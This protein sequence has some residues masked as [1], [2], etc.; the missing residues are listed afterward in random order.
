M[1]G[2]KALEATIKNTGKETLPVHLALDGPDADRTHRK[3]CTV[4]SATIPSATE[5]TLV[6]PIVPVPPR[7]SEWL[8]DGKEKTFPWSDSSEKSGYNLAKANALSIYVYH[9]RQ[10]YVYEVARL[11]AIP[12][13]DPASVNEGSVGWEPRIQQPS[14]NVQ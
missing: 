10:E 7:P 12:T 6:V 8:C 13:D 3:N 14:R 1:A 9:P 5:K 11:R 4:I 2:L